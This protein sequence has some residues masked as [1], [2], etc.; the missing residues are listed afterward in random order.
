[1]A[2]GLGAG[3]VNIQFL[4]RSIL[5]GKEEWLSQRMEIP[6]FDGEESENWVLR[7]E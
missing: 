3:S 6:T 5:G 1:M 2:S 4:Y 7:V